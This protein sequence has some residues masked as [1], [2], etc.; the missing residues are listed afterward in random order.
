[1][2][3]PGLVDRKFSRRAKQLGAQR[4]RVIEAIRVDQVHHFAAAQVVHGEAEHALDRRTG[5]D[6]AALEGPG[7]DQRVRAVLDHGL[8]A[9]PA[10]R[11][12]PLAPLQ[13]PGGER[14]QDQHDGGGEQGA[15]DGEARVLAPGREHRVLVGAAHHEQGEAAHRRGVEQHLALHDRTR[16]PPLPGA[17]AAHRVADARTGQ[18]VPPHAVRIGHTGDD[19]ALIRKQGD[20][21]AAAQVDHAVE[22]VEALELDRR[23]DRAAAR[24]LEL[25]RQQ[26]APL[27]AIGLGIGIAY[28]KAVLA[29]LAVK[30]RG[31]GVERVL[32]AAGDFP[33]VGV[34]HQQG[35]DLAHVLQLGAQARQARRHPLRAAELG[36]VAQH[37]VNG[38]ERGGGLLGDD[39]RHVGEAAR[40][41]A[42]RIL[43][44]GADL[45][46]GGGDVD[47]NQNQPERHD[48][49]HERNARQ[50]RAHARRLHRSYLG[51]GPIS[52]ATAWRSSARFSGLAKTRAA[53]APTASFSLQPCPEPK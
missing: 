15:V 38:L 48:R 41:A 1:M 18:A 32:V 8:V 17:V 53:P 23:R 34:E 40:G 22:P 16:H 51:G 5:V 6:D 35:S 3:Q 20:E 12:R 4:V 10:L 19:R 30:G 28:V 49:A 44:G 25:A 31:R 21:R 36:R 9:L 2:Q 26:Q 33:A 50:Q 11:E 42:L 47:R 45:P 24:P 46:R 27:L 13:A 39:V 7:E 37:Q 52:S 14:D 43:A 29:L